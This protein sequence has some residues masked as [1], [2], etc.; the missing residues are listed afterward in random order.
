[1][2]PRA[3]ERPITYDQASRG[4]LPDQIDRYRELADRELTS[5]SI[6]T[7]Q[8]RG[9]WTEERARILDPDK[10]PPLTVAEHLEMIALGWR[11]A[12]HYRHP[13]QVD[14]AVRAGASWEQIAAAA[15]TTEKAARA[16]YCEWVEGQHQYAGMSDADYT[17][18]LD[19]AF[20]VD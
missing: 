16:A 5:R 15:G 19:L 13:S 4:N 18:A 17:A 20:R 12:S 2:P 11:I 3:A 8:A 10:Y 14:N 1:M 7:L 9:E 6:A